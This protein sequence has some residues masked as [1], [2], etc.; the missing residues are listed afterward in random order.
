MTFLFKITSS[1]FYLSYPICPRSSGPFY[2][3]NYYI[4]WVTTSW[5]NS[6]ISHWIITTNFIR[7]AIIPSSN[8]SV[9]DWFSNTFSVV[10]PDSVL[11]N[12]DI[13]DLESGSG[14]VK[15]LEPDFAFQITFRTHKPQ[16]GSATLL[17]SFCSS[18]FFYQ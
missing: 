17:K 7:S 18:V 9:A 14:F 15:Y 8:R 13:F 12:C 2:I 10:Y 4:K 1:S 5:T 6:R 16:S 11:R 3:V